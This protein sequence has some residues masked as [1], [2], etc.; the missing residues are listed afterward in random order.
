MCHSSLKTARALPPNQNYLRRA[1]KPANNFASRSTAE[2]SSGPI[3]PPLIRLWMAQYIRV[4]RS[5]PRTRPDR[6]SPKVSSRGRLLIGCLR[7]A[8]VAPS[9]GVDGFP[10]E[11]AKKARFCSSPFMNLASCRPPWHPPF[12]ASGGRARYCLPGRPL[13]LFRQLSISSRGSSGMATG[14][15]PIQP[16]GIIQYPHLASAGL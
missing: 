16:C 13:G 3:C 9:S 5:H 10:K 4:N 6:I 11:Q 2:R 14:V 1:A 15:I 8:E 12:S 7:Y